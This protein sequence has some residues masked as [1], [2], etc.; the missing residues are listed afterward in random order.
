MGT[1]FDSLNG[2]AFYSDKMPEVVEILEKSGKLID[3][4][5]AKVVEMDDQ[6]IPPCLIIKSNGS[7]TYA[8]RDL[9]AI[10]Y[11]ARTYDFDKA[12]YITSYEQSLHFKQVFSTARYLGIDEKYVKGLEHVPFGMVQLKTGKMSTREGNTIKL[13]DLLNESIEKS[14]A[15]I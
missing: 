12:L 14:K 13:E 5:G 4:N 2:E 15:I 3:S 8:T 11:R 10:L 9:A 7:T 1:K 6:N